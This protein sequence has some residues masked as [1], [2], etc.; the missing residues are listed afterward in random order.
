[1]EKQLNTATKDFKI[2]VPTWNDTFNLPEG[3]YSIE[4]IPDYFEY[5]M[6]KA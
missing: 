1:M 3:R 5:I 4:E 2:S 6:K